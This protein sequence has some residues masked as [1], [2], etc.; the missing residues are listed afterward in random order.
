MALQM[1]DPEADGEPEVMI[2]RLKEKKMEG[3]YDPEEL[4]EKADTLMEAEEIKADHDLMKAL[5]PYLDKK[6]KAVKSIAD[7]KKKYNDVKLRDMR[8]EQGY[9]AKV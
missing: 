2:S 1:E 6:A 7:L 9:K 8:A 5:S 4:Q 3:K